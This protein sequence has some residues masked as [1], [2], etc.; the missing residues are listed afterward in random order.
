MVV[1]GARCEKRCR[2]K[3]MGGSETWRATTLN[4]RNRKK[5]GG[6]ERREGTGRI[7]ANRHIVKWR[8]LIE[9]IRNK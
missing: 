8:Y 6:R 2:G 9:F 3:N 5:K 1:G 7:T 4:A